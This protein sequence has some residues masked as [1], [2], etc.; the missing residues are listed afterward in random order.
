MNPLSREASS[1][2]NLLYSERDPA[3]AEAIL[4]E[5]GSISMGERCVPADPLFVDAAK[6]D[7]RLK[8]ESPAIAMGFR[9]FDTWGLTGQVGPGSE[10][11]DAPGQA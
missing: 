8:S 7:F 1:D 11:Q 6:G 4:K 5:L 3:S 9:P 10:T 2:D